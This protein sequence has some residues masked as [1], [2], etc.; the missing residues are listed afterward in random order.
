M[1]NDPQSDVLSNKALIGIHQNT[2]Q[3]EPLEASVGFPLVVGGYFVKRLFFTKCS[4]PSFYRFCSP[5]LIR[6]LHFLG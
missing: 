2:V 1:I 3:T 6:A 4:S 5:R